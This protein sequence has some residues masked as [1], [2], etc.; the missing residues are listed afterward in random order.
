MIPCLLPLLE[1]GRDLS[2]SI[3]NEKPSE[4][5]GGKSHRR[6]GPPTCGW[7]SWSLY[8]L[9]SS[10]M[11]SSCSSPTAQVSLPRWGFPRAC[12]SSKLWFSVFSCWSLQF[13]GWQGALWSRFSE[14]A[15][16]CSFLALCSAFC[17]L[18]GWSDDF[19]ALYTL[20][21]K[22]EVGSW[23]FYFGDAEEFVYS[24]FLLRLDKLHPGGV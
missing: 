9:G 5:S 7:Y 15:K 22:P 11:T 21:Q 23:N 24:C 2:P 4:A 6:M 10:T 3:H 20:E 1:A 12:C 13:W 14:P 18:L 8:L 19:Q 17:L 16:S